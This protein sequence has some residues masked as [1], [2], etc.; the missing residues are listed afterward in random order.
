MPQRASEPFP[1]LTSQFA[2]FAGDGLFVHARDH[3]VLHPHLGVDYHQANRRLRSGL[4]EVSNVD[5][6]LAEDGA[7]RSLGEIT[8]VVRQSDFLTGVLVTPDFVASGAGTVVLIT[9]R[10]QAPGDLPICETRQ[11][12]H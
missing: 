4:Q 11:T 9:E 6:R 7:E 1:Q 2:R 8:G 5:A 10:P 3:P 12:A